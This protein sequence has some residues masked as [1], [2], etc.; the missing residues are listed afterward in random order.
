[1]RCPRFLPALPTLLWVFLFG[2]ISQAE[3]AYIGS[4]AC[5]NCH[6]QALEDWQQSH[7]RQAMRSATSDSVLGNFDNSV[8]DHYGQRTEFYKKG[9]RYFVRT[10]NASG[11]MQEFAI[12]YTFGFYPLQQYLIG[13]DDG[14]YQAL[15]VAWDSRP[16]AEGG[17]RWFHLYPDEAIP[18]DDPLHWT[19]AFQNWNSRCASCHSTNLQ[20]HYSEQD[21]SYK[22][23]WS[24]LTVGCEA[25]HGAG[26]K[27]LAWAQGDTN[28]PSK[29]LVTVLASGGDWQQ[30]TDSPTRHNTQ[31]VSSDHQL[32]VCAGCHSR[33][34]EIAHP[35]VAARFLDNYTPSLLLQGLYYPDGQIEDEVYV[36]GS[37]LQSK[38]HAAGVTCSN[39]HQPHSG[40]L[41]AEGN[42]LCSQC[43]APSTFDQAS[44]HHHPSGSTGAQCVNCHMPE[45]NYMVVDPRR[46]HSFRIPQPL[47]SGLLQTPNACT[48]CHS[49]KDNAWAKKSVQA[50][51]G[52]QP[53]RDEHASTLAIARTDSPAALQPLLKLAANAQAA[54]IVRATA[55][56]ESGRFP[57]RETVTQ[58]VEQL[59]S[60]DA[61]LRM[62]AVRALDFM[63]PDQRYGVMHLLIDDP[64]KSVRMAVAVAL[65]GVQTESLGDKRKA[66]L[67]ALFAEYEEAMAQNADMP[68]SEL[69]LGVYYV[70]RGQREAAV[71]AY[72]QALHLSPGFTPALLNLADLYR[73]MGQDDKAKPLLMRVIELQPGEA[74]AYHA[75]GLLLVRGK[76]IAQAMPYLKK[77]V[78]LA[79]H[80]AR[81]SYVYGVA[82][83][84][85]GQR[86][87]AMEVLQEAAQSHPYDQQIRAAL[88]AY[89]EQQ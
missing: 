62:A 75:M 74:P 1:M 7:H 60:E 53:L 41:R 10:D 40:K 54:P 59:Y 36:Y 43:H 63:P 20:K 42:D 81:Y 39:C 70:A 22:T 34:Q 25:C 68:G 30:S 58:A 73:A 84:S 69:N 66:A 13:F 57:S 88:Q 23:T 67:V 24:E 3:T 56:Q 55:L 72:K 26:E 18:H 61:L 9:G 6:Q 80:I 27:H 5:G 85:N 37:F 51:Y 82:L 45:R 29:G 16:A 35:N 87:K 48:T 17:Q 89:S 76:H 19:G 44:H 33:R 79:P 38:M 2:S 86:Q 78:V 50:W 8:F 4:E 64:I 71:R 11:E 31:G 21:D 52:H 65:A 12:A 14:R 46:D 15:S 32:A 28:I 49:D 47:L 83:H 77:A